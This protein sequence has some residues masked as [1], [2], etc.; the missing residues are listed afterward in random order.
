MPANSSLSDGWWALWRPAAWLRVTGTD[1][2][3]FLQGQFTNDV[4]NARNG[5][6]YGLW[7]D[8]KG[9]VRADSFV[10]RLGEHEFRVGSYFSAGST[11]CARL[12]SHIVADDVSLEDQT[13]RWCGISFAGVNGERL[14]TKLGLT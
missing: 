8:A 14:R 3:A 13:N 4:F 11:I 9:K 10:L 2:E 1:A 6:V 7:L 5:A 12:E